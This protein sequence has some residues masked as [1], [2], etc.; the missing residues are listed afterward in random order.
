M[1]GIA[2]AISTEFTPG[3]IAVPARWY[4]HDESVYVNPDLD[5]ENNGE[6]VLTDYYEKSL[7]SFLERR[8]QDPHSPAYENFGFIHPE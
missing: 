1:M 4:F 2:T 7:A 8:K 6:C 3:D 5:P